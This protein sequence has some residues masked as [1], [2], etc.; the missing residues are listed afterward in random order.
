MRRRPERVLIVDDHAGIRLILRA[1]ALARDDFEV[2]GEAVDGYEAITCAETLQPDLVLLDVAMPG[3]DGLEA[4][5]RV[6]RA[7]PGARVV[8]LTAFD[9]GLLD[10]P[11]GV[12]Y[13]Q[14]DSDLVRVFD[15]LAA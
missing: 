3:M 5:P 8:V 7:A 10:L 4:L 15:R 11:P 9:G 13:V 2:V 1:A 6:R 12:E 14:K